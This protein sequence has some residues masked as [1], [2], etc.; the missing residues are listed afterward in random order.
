MRHLLKL[1]LLIVG[2]LAACVAQVQA[3]SLSPPEPVK[4]DDVKVVWSEVGPVVL[5]TAQESVIP[6]F[7]D[8]TVAG[9]IQGAL[10]GKKSPRPLSHD[11]M[12]TIL[13][14]YGMTVVQV[15]IS[16]KEQVY[17]GELTMAVAGQ[18]RVFDCRSSDGIALAIHFGTPIFVDPA[19]LDK[20]RQGERPADSQIVL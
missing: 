12:H 13:Q 18:T 15:R 6:I 14:T 7:V 4:V 1:L 19:L 17:Y 9:S 16:L 5:L 2:C 3:Q 10:T 11:L 20:A 8:P